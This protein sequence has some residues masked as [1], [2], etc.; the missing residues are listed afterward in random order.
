MELYII[1]RDIPRV[2]QRSD[3]E[4]RAGAKRSNQVLAELGDGIEWE[5][6]YI[7]GDRIYCV[8]RAAN[9]DVIR[10]HA[11]RAGV[12]ASRISRVMATQ[13]PSSGR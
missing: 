12:P 4:L 9:E 8:Y 1:E 11:Q 6:S 3:E 5:H 10:E 2:G 7:T 13:D